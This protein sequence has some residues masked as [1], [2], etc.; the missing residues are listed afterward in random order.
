MS[1]PYYIISPQNPITLSAEKK[2]NCK[3][4]F[5]CGATCLPK[6][7]K[8]GKP[9]NCKNT[10]SSETGKQAA[11]ALKNGVKKS[12]K[13][14]K[15]KEEDKQFLTPGE[16]PKGFKG[17]V[18]LD[19]DG[20]YVSYSSSRISLQKYG[21]HFDTDRFKNGKNIAV[22]SI[23]FNINDEWSAGQIK[24]PKVAIKAGL[25]AL[26]GIERKLKDFPDGQLLVNKPYSNDGLGDKRARLYSKKGFGE[27]DKDGFQW[28][29]IRGGKLVPVSGSDIDKILGN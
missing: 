16:S 4:G 19:S 2:R 15:K 9:T 1:D 28:G 29:V 7:T 14:S 10:V 26:N 5:P 13:T 22:H 8:S 18:K 12:G 24:D 6:Y 23:E 3:K 17:K 25:S 11:E 21:T 20:N 27:R